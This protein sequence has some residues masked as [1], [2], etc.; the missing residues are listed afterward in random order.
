MNIL[1]HLSKI[2]NIEAYR[3][4]YVIAEIGINH[5]GELQEA[6]KLIDA[7]CDAGVDAVKFQKRDLERLYTQKILD[8]PNSA[9]WTF[10][11]LIP[12]LQEVELSEDDYRVIKKKCDELGIDL[13]ITPFDL[14]SADFCNQLGVDAIKIGSADMVNFDLI[15]TCFSFKKPVI[16]STGMWTEQEIRNAVRKYKTFGDNDFF[17]LLA[18]STYPTPYESINLE[19]LTKLKSIHDLVGYSG[20]ERGT[21]IPVA[22]A[23]L[24]AR[25]VEKHITFDKNQTGPDHKA[26]MHPDEFKEMVQ[27]LRSLRLALGTNKVVNQAEKLAKETFAKS[28]YAKDNLPIGHFLQL[29]DVYFTSPGKGLY[30]HEINE[31]IGRELK[32]E[33]EKDGFLTK[34]HFE[35]I[36]KVKDWKLPA[37]SKRW[38]VKC[39]FHDFEEYKRLNSP[40]VEFHCS[41]RDMDID[42]KGFSKTSQLVIHAPEIFD[43]KL[44]D[45]CS[46]DPDI[47]EGS[48]YLLQRAIDKT[49]AIAPNFPLKKPK[50]V[51]HLGGMSLQHVVG[52]E[53][54]QLMMERATDNFKKLKFNPD[55]IDILPENLPP[56]PWYLGGQWFQYGFMHAQDMIDF[57]KHFNLMMTYDI[58]HAA[59]HCNHAEVS[60]EEYTSQIL[61]H[62][63]HFHISDASGIDG[64]GVQINEGEVNFDSFFEV[65]AGDKRD[66]SWVTEIWSGHVNHGAGC[67]HSMHRLGKYNKI[68]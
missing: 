61:S 17:M 46:D 32:C 30:S 36:V 14:K 47:V 60:L 24:G 26:S 58:C 45:I 54:T 35:E 13:I 51:V 56:R 2:K 40:V 62:V 19:F 22:A 8:D 38:G 48:I 39:R 29:S 3:D 10:E 12:I 6:L 1:D 59:L 28:A 52:D 57:C 21:F 7:S 9:E 66:F 16:I 49:I 27:H 67:R 31:Y 15:K 63:S 34:H 44:V 42:F 5:N 20:H 18:N 4:T 23:S 53:N 43:R 68:I 50:F 37:F 55:D 33:V 11:Y 41:Q 64:E 65:L 25:I